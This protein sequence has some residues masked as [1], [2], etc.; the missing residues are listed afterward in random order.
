MAFARKTAG[1]ALHSKGSVVPPVGE[2]YA[3]RRRSDRGLLYLP[4]RFNRGRNRRSTYWR[5]W[6]S[7]K[8]AVSNKQGLRST[9]CRDEQ[10]RF[11]RWLSCSAVDQEGRRHR[12]NRNSAARLDS[13]STR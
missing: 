5:V 4:L 1:D 8:C 7:G 2:A 10:T 3:A 11:R 12:Y 13:A 6:I 9:L